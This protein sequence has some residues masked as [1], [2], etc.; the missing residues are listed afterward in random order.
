MPNNYR[1][2]NPDLPRGR[3]EELGPRALTLSELVALLVG[4]GFGGSSAV[5]IGRSVSAAVSGSARM[6]ASLDLSELRELPGL[7]EV[8][9]ARISA[10]VEM[11]RRAITEPEGDADYIRSGADVFR[12]FGPRLGDARQEEFHALLLNARNRVLREHL[13]T[14]GTLDAS[15]VHPREVFRP[16]I[17]ACAAAVILVHNHPSGDPVPSEEDRVVTDRLVEAGRLVGIPVMDH[18]VIG[19]NNWRSVMMGAPEGSGW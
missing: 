10:A 17:V 15:L 8:N 6:L 18:V 11:G 1:R 14:R 4:S 19:C 9:S 13:V 7:G 16:A 3:I 5:E 2:N 12:R